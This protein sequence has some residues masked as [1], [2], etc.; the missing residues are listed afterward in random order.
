MEEERR[1][2]YV[3]ITRA[4]DL[5]YMTLARKRMLI[6]QRDSFS[7]TYTLQS[8]FLKEITPGLLAGYYP[9]S[10]ENSYNQQPEFG[11]DDSFVNGGSIGNKST[12]FGGG[13]N[14]FGNS[15]G[16][17]YDRSGSSNSSGSG[18]S[19]RYGSG[20][21]NNYD[22]TSNNYGSSSTNNGSR[23]GYY[24]RGYAGNNDSGR[25]QGNQPASKPRAMRQGES[26]SNGNYVSSTPK[27]PNDNIRYQLD[28]GLPAPA[29]NSFEHL[30]VGDTVQHP[31]FGTG[32]VVQVIG[33]QDKELYNIEFLEAGKRLLDP[34]FAKLIKA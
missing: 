34:R 3:A 30:A 27:K 26:S 19:N 1:L 9:R 7:T 14:R 17:N 24:G 12:S 25:S 16:T 13:V 31:K 32:T 6:G 2:M 18:G 29:D 20:S 15:G 28:A 21:G 10:V 23:N 33:D 5:L 22:R 8:R 4:A 11:D